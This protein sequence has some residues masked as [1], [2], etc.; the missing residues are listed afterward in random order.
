MFEYIQH[1]LW[2]RKSRRA[3]VEGKTAFCVRCDDPIVSGDFVG[4]CFLHDSPEAKLIHAGFHFSLTNRNAFCE[5]GAIGSAV[6][7]G[8]KAVNF[9]KPLAAT[10]S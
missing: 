3:V 2:K 4:I 1:A 9:G 6:W 8:E 5:T 10:L 7:D